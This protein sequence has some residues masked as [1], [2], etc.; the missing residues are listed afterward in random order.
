MNKKRILLIGLSILAVLAIIPLAPLARFFTAG[1]R[2]QVVVPAPDYWPTDGWR[3]SAPEEQ[4]IDSEKLARGLRSLHENQV[5]IDSLLLIRNGYL[6]TDAH[7]APY[8]GSFPHDLAS[9]TKSVTTTLVAIAAAQG[10]LD[11]D[12]PVVSFFPDRT[13]ANL[14]ARKQR[15]TV[16]HLM[17]MV[18]G[19][20]SGCFD[21]DEPTLDAMRSQPDWVQAALDRPMVAEP[22]TRNCYDSP[23]MHLLSAILQ[24]VSGMTE[25]EFA[26]QNLFGPLGIRQAIWESDPQGYTRGWGDLHLLPEDAAK[27]GYL[28]LQ[29]GQWEGKQIVPEAWVLDSVK[30]HSKFF[31]GDFGYGYGWWVSWVDYLASGRGGQNVRVIA[32]RNAILVVTGDY[33]AYSDVQKWLLPILFAAGEPLPVNPH[34]AAALE[35]VLADIQQEVLPSGVPSPDLVKAVS[36]RTYG[37]ESNPIGVETV[38]L[39]LADPAQATLYTRMNGSD[40]SWTISLGG[41]YLQMPNGEA[42]RGF[43]LDARSFQFDIFDIGVLHRQLYFEGDGLQVTLPELNIK[44]A[45]RVQ[46]P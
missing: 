41:R 17:G 15:M 26:R 29:R 22:G 16:R 10:K 23:G 27:I 13:I 32:S 45:C 30:P 3:T 1:L 28:W 4:G 12:Q 20:Q 11:L 9:V 44:I 38:R 33:F 2:E 34:G 43:W 5:P 21:G 19:M 40:V 46:N 25:L 37:C 24:K 18:N 36:G 39:D 42:F 8:D 35:A 7:F 14:D 31:G 6:V